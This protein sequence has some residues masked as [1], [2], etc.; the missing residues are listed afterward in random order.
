MQDWYTKCEQC[1]T[2]REGY[3]WWS[4][5]L[6]GAAMLG[7]W[8]GSVRC[9]GLWG[10]GGVRWEAGSPAPPAVLPVRQPRQTTP[11]VRRAA[12]HTLA[13]TIW[14]QEGFFKLVYIRKEED[15]FHFSKAQS[16][17]CQSL[18]AAARASP[19][20][21]CCLVTCC[22]ISPLPRRCVGILAVFWSRGGDRGGSGGGR[23]AALSAPMSAEGGGRAPG[24]RRPPPLRL[25]PPRL[26]GAT[27]SAVGNPSLA[28]VRA[29]QDDNLCV[30]WPP[31]PLRRYAINVGRG[32]VEEAHWGGGTAVK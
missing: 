11:G 6:W 19:L 32:E 26:L 21:V 12:S 9:R 22:C 1:V 27:L 4:I 29:A 3:V 10:V 15:I 23:G 20:V 31:P 17:C 14:R 16:L 28:G 2:G 24:P 25:G 8:W 5:K 18:T 30:P 13:T 7:E